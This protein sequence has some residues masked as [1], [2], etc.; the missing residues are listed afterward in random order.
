[1]CDMINNLI[2]FKMAT[3]S[4]PAFHV[5]TKSAAKGEAS[6][7]IVS[8]QDAVSSGTF[9]INL[10]VQYDPAVNNYPTGTLAIKCDMS[11]ST[12]G[13]YTATSVELINSYGK[14]N[15]TI[16]L[17][18][19]CKADTAAPV[20]LGCRYWVMIANNKQANA[21]GTPDIVGFV[22]HDRNGNRI[23]Y[24]TGPVKSGDIV[25]APM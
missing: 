4:I 12:D 18:G 14:H 23:A 13:V 19:Q 9:T 5:S 25:V 22:I 24:G 20:P 17:T 8:R 2:S 6:V 16:Y 15:P 10:N 21:N 11:D 7:H 1:M 3:T